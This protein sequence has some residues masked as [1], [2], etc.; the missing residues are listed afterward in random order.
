LNV[1]TSR[2]FMTNDQYRVKELRRRHHRNVPQTRGPDLKLLGDLRRFDVRIRGLQFVQVTHAGPGVKSNELQ[3]LRFESRA[4]EAFV[5]IE[6]YRI[7]G[8][9]A[10]Q[11]WS[12][13]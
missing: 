4:R 8:M 10:C 9:L 2:F 7:P 3:A 11:W 6:K 13:G 5:A 12:R 1:E